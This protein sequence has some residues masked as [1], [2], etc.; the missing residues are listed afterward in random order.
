V[1]I[2]KHTEMKKKL[3]HTTKAKWKE[4]KCKKQQKKNINKGRH[5][6]RQTSRQVRSCRITSFSSLFFEK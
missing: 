3:T 4:K 2:T 1:K 6:G 5:A